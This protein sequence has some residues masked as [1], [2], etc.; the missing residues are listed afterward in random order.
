[1]LTLSKGFKKPQDGDKG[2]VFWDALEDDI[3]QLNDHTHNGANSS[4]LET[5]AVTAK[6]Q[7]ITASWGSISDGR[8]SKVVTLPSGYL[9]DEIMISFRDWTTGNHYSLQVDKVSS[10]SYRVYT[11]DNTLHLAA[12]YTS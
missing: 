12:V 10:N 3:Q 2:S 5:S 8:Y 9:F 7:E 4:K 1:M 11:N 6:I